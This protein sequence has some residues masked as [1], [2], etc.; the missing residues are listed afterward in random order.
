MFLSFYAEDKLVASRDTNTLQKA[1]DI[2]AGLFDRVGF[3]VGTT[4]TKVI[5]FT[6][7]RVNTPLSQ[8]AYVRPTN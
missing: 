2:L 5:I 4:K 1:V 8:D 7:G 6:A 3:C